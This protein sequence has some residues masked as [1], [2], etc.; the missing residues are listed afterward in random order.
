VGARTP[1]HRYDVHPG[2]QNMQGW[3]AQLKDKAGRSLDE[4]VRFIRREGP[5]DEKSLRGWLR[6]DHQVGTAYGLDA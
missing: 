4:W 1:M 6:K 2:V 5:G 3:I